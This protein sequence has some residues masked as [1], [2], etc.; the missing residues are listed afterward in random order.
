MAPVDA[1]ELLQPETLRLIDSLGEADSLGDLV[2]LVS[3]LRAQGHPTP[4]I[5]QAIE[6]VRLRRKAQAKFGHFAERMLFTEAGLEQATRLSVAAH[7]AGRIQR[8]GMTSIA[9]LG[10][11]L[12][13]DSMAFGA[14]GLAV[15]AIDSDATTAALAAYNLA[16]FDTV[17][18]SHGL[19]EDTDLSSFDAIWLDPARRTDSSSRLRPEHWSPPL[20][21]A[22]EKASVMPAG[23]KLAPGL[24]HSSIPAD[25]EAQWVSDRGS[26]VELVYWSGALARPGISR[27]ALVL[28]TEHAAEMSG[29]GPSENQPTGPLGEY[30]YEPD[31][32]VIRAQLI[33]DLARSLEGWM[34]SP[35]IAYITSN[36]HTPTPFAQ[37]F[38]VEEVLPLNQKAIQ[39]W[40]RSAGIGALEIK[41]R[42]VDI[43]PA[44]FRQSLSLSG[45]NDATL[46]L[47]RLEG[48]RT[49]IVTTRT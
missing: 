31:G 45:D 37:S 48:K 17:T 12:G 46:F 8:S 13:G 4:R 10:C 43:D 44:Q 27:S 26:V 3:S 34:V 1:G 19:A 42:G 49:A 22:V 28:G 5:H 35:D 7:H 32:A 29:S 6:Q 41:K 9:D 2:G 14:L 39:R 11:G 23:I 25:G 15:E 20:S 38:A 33:G 47:T 30:L 36:Q 18:V 21:W 40:V 16:P 24:D